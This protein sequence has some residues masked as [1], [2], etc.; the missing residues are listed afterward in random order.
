MKHL[1][2]AAV[3]FSAAV[4][5]RA[6]QNA[7]APAP[8]SVSEMSKRVEAYDAQV[9]EDTKHVAH[10][11]AVA[12][13][14]KDVVKLTCVNDVIV[15]LKAQQNVYDMAH[16]EYEKAV[17]GDASG[18]E[19]AQTAFG[20]LSAAGTGIKKLRDDAEACIG[21]PELYK[22]ES[23]VDVTQPDFQDDPTSDDP[24]VPETEP[25]GYASP[26]GG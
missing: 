2:V 25:P 12:R 19:Q 4:T 9:A 16:G 24:F 6:D 26:F 3:L 13:K 5:V 10:L 17:S 23:D 20:D 22:Q 7:A 1:G 15:Q 18:G 8:L 11:R 21:V 14:Q